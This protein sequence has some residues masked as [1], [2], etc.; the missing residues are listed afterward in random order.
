M[1]E[2]GT[3]GGRPQPT[4]APACVLPLSYLPQPSPHQVSLG[5]SPALSCGFRPVTKAPRFPVC[6]MGMIS[7]KAAPGAAGRM[8][9]RERQAG[10]CR[11]EPAGPREGRAQSAPGPHFCCP[12]K[13]ESPT[14]L[15]GEAS[16]STPGPCGADLPQHNGVLPELP[17]PHLCEEGHH[18]LPCHPVGVCQDPFREEPGHGLASH[19]E[20]PGGCAPCCLSWPLGGR[21]EPTGRRAQDH[22]AFW[23]SPGLCPHRRV[24]GVSVRPVCIRQQRQTR[25]RF[26]GYFGF[27]DKPQ[28]S[29]TCSSLEKLPVSSCRARTDVLSGSPWSGCRVL[30]KETRR[31]PL[32]GLTRDC[33][34]LQGGDISDQGSPGLRCNSPAFQVQVG[35]KLGRHISPVPRGKR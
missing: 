15:G 9:G 25:A 12:G 33:V 13:G 11:P 20:L 14:P 5:F 32:H 30:S 23:A 3:V 26:Q 34:Q 22:R 24:R 4:A 8:D 31:P 18:Q 17:G 10:L 1:R 6:K 29:P 21:P 16:P 35:S 19:S 28:R 7:P 27:P 2:G